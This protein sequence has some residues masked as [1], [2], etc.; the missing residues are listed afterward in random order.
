MA[1]HQATKPSE[2]APAA[3][4]CQPPF[5]I[6]VAGAY[7]GGHGAAFAEHARALRAR[8]TRANFHSFLLSALRFRQRKKYGRHG[9]NGKS[10]IEKWASGERSA[11]NCA[12]HSS[13]LAA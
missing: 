13:S 9:E 10:K 12:A 2:N 3:T 6:N 8:A 4:G 7:G 11:I 5:A 1:G